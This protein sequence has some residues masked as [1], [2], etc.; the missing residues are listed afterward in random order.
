MTNREV[1]KPGD[2]SAPSKDTQQ[3]L[4][5]SK[6]ENT[7]R[8]G[9][10]LLEQS[11]NRNTSPALSGMTTAF[12]KNG[13]DDLAFEA[14][15][16]RKRDRKSLY[17]GLIAREQ[18]L[19]GDIEAW[20]KTVNKIDDPSCLA[21][22]YQGL[23]T[24]YAN[25]GEKEM[26]RNNILLANE[27][28]AKGELKDVSDLWRSRF[29]DFTMEKLQ[30]T[31]TALTIVRAME[32]SLNKSLQYVD[33]I[34]YLLKNGNKEEVPALISEADKNANEIINK[35]GSNYNWTKPSAQLTVADLYIRTGQEE[36]GKRRIDSVLEQK[37]DL[38]EMADKL[39]Q[40]GCVDT[41]LYITPRLEKP[42]TQL[43]RYESCAEILIKSGEKERAKNILDQA[44]KIAKDLSSQDKTND[45]EYL[46]SHLS[47]IA[48]EY[49]NLGEQ[50]KSIELFDLAFS[51]LRYTVTHI[52]KFDVEASYLLR[53][54]VK[55]GYFEGAKTAVKSIFDPMINFNACM[56]IVQGYIDSGKY[57]EAY[58]S[59]V[60]AE[61]LAFK[62]EPEQYIGGVQGE[63][64]LEIATSYYKLKML[65]KDITSAK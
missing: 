24:H 46:P 50:E 30:D 10:S 6:F 1:K 21:P 51:N 48:E 59:L 31:N 55:A 29:Y 3:I 34:N 36:E 15:E 23:A 12:A 63:P 37:T 52:R 39:I 49:D 45:T 35:D 19:R 62:V 53:K 27:Y 11:K 65:Q 57:D 28:I 58:K 38:T 43:G 40:F 41:A 22:A 16:K 18:A 7:L 17:Y 14:V 47:T 8:A 25:T 20:Q 56:E 26:A 13:Y 60:N 2:P 32:P 54:E 61:K 4:L 9:L 64:Q 33:L 5:S 42:L 44:A